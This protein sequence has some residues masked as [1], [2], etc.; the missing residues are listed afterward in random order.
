MNVENDSSDISTS[1]K[2]ESTGE[3]EGGGGVRGDG[4]EGEIERESPLTKTLPL[5]R[6]RKAQRE[7]LIKSQKVFGS[8]PDSLTEGREFESQR[9]HNYF[10]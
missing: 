9:A 7:R 3:R 6:D 8:P 2:Q 5:M 1:I 10:C 4:R